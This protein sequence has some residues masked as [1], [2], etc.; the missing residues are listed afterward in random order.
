MAFSVL[1]EGLNHRMRSNA[2]RKRK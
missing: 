2:H 1:V